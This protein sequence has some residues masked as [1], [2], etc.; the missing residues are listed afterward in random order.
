[1]GGDTNSRKKFFR[2]TMEEIGGVL[3]KNFAKP[4][5]V[6]RIAEASDYRQSLR[7][8]A[9]ESPHSTEQHRPVLLMEAAEVLDIEAR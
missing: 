7:L 3:R 5:D 9:P 8:G 1:M 6:T 4:V 2:A